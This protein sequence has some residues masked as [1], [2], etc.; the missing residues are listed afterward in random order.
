MLAWMIRTTTTGGPD[1]APS[2]DHG[3]RETDQSRT[4]RE[5]AVSLVREDVKVA[6]S[7]AGAGSEPESVDDRVLLARV[8]AQVRGPGSGGPDQ[9]DQENQAGG[10]GLKSAGPRGPVRESTAR[11]PATVTAPTGDIDAAAVAAYR[12]SLRAG[13][14]LSERKLA[15]AFGTTSRRWA[16]N[17]MAEARQGLVA[18]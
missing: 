13:K 5:P 1:H 8:V 4:M 16:R 9:A 7:A 10:P 14:P 6:D 17:R 2:A 12:A 3:V 18:V 11:G 15:G